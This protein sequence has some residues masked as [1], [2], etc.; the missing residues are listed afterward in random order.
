[1]HRRKIALPLLLGLVVSLALGGC[2]TSGTSD[3]Q[4]RRSSTRITFE[5]LQSMEQFS[6]Y[7]TIQQLRPNWL[8][9]RAGV[10]PRLVVDGNP[11]PGGMNALR[12]Y[13]TRDIQEV[14]YLSSS[15]ATTRF[16]TGFDGGAILVTTRR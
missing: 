1:M 3:G 9:A 12:T 16:G 10:S 13:R 5:E 2:A 15:D 6:L 14:R 11:E 7:E 4:P 8:R